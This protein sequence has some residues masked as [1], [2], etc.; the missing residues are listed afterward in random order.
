MSTCS[1]LCGQ[2][3]YISSL[4]AHNRKQFC[5]NSSLIYTVDCH[6][7]TEGKL[8]GVIAAQPF[9]TCKQQIKS[10]RNCPLRLFSP[11]YLRVICLFFKG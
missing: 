4:A 8:C 2:S 3:S 6:Q 10:L 9:A 7:A 5:I 11:Q 1:Q